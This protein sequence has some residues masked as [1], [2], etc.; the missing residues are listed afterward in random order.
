[1]VCFVDFLI[2]L[3]P[4]EVGIFRAFPCDGFVPRV[5]NHIGDVEQLE[6]KENVLTEFIQF[7]K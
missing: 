2:L 7:Q 4:G 3:K 1:M 6:K 5:N